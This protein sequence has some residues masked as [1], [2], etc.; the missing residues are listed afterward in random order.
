MDMAGFDFMGFLEDHMFGV[1]VGAS[2]VIIGIIRL[3]MSRA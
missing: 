3:L 2:I 1:V